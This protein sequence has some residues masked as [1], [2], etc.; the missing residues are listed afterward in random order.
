[1]VNK[2]LLGF[3]HGS[4]PL[5]SHPQAGLLAA[6]GVA[7]LRA[8]SDSKFTNKSSIGFPSHSTPS[9]GHPQAGLLAALDGSNFQTLT[10][11][12]GKLNY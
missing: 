2:V 4:M 1:M 3:P 5:D 7:I 9:G 6:L 10:D 11:F 8:S 12:P